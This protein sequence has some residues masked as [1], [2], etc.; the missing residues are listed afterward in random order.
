M[1]TIIEHHPDDQEFTATAGSHGG[2]L[3]YS[4]PA[5]GVLDF[6]HTFVEEELRGTGVGE[7]LAQAGLAFARTQGLRVRTSCEFMTGFVRQHPEF[8][9][10]QDD[11][12]Y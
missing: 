11:T 2:E 12:E 6:T 7:Q 3:A 10:L 1:A 9:D 4:R 5:E 8:Q